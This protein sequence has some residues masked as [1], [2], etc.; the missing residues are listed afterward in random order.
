MFPLTGLKTLRL[1][2]LN[3]LNKDVTIMPVQHASHEK[4]WREPVGFF[5]LFAIGELRPYRT[6]QHTM[7]PDSNGRNILELVTG[8]LPYP[9]FP[10]IFKEGSKVD[11][12]IVNSGTGVFAIVSVTYLAMCVE[13]DKVS[14]NKELPK[15]G[16]I[17]IFLDRVTISNMGVQMGPGSGE[18]KVRIGICSKM[19]WH[20]LGIFLR[21]FKAHARSLSFF[22]QTWHGCQGPYTDT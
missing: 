3:I 17:D 18:P 15:F 9:A 13:S 4:I 14:I 10:T 16:S 11:T 21:S 12:D 1:P 5:R 2:F 7:I 19:I 6:M 8:L 22:S 20:R